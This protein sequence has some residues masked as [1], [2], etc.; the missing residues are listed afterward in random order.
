MDIKTKAAIRRSLAEYNE[1]IETIARIEFKKLSSS[2]LIDFSELVNIGTQVVHHFCSTTDITNFNNSY[3]STAIKWAIRNEVR[4]RY[5]WYSQKTKKENPSLSEDDI[6]AV[7]ADIREAVY[8]TILSIDEMAEAENP[9]QI[10]DDTR[11]PEELIAFNELSEAIKE[12]MKK[13]PQRE[14]DLIEAKFFHDKKLR[15]LSED[16]DISPSRISRIIQSG[17]NKIRKELEKNNLA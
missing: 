16:F 7:N 15:E 11:T 17:L 3:I 12:A 1:L 5:K 2:Y 6:S 9:T 10:K 14:H 13:L 8:K 4:R